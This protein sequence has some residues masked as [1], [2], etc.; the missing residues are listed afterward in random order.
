MILFWSL[1]ALLVLGAL[2][3]VLWPLLRVR[4]SGTGAAAGISQALHDRQRNELQ[5][6]YA[7]G[8]IDDVQLIAAGRE[9]ESGYTDS[10]NAHAT[11]ATQGRAASLAAP[12]ITLFLLPIVAVFLY[13]Y[14]GS[15]E[16]VTAEVVQIQI[17][18]QHSV[19]DM[20]VRLKERLQ[21]EPDDA[22]GWMLLGRSYM[23]MKY[24]EEAAQAFQNASQ[25]VT[26]DSQLL[27]DYAEALMLA[28]NNNFSEQADQLVNQALELQPDNA[29]AL[30]IAGISAASRGDQGSATQLWRKLLPLLPPGSEE[31]TT[32][33]N[34]IDE[35]AAGGSL[36]LIPSGSTEGASTVSQGS[37]I[38][39]AQISVS[40]QLSPELAAKVSPDDT[41]FIFARAAQGP[42][43]PLAIVRGTAADLPRQ[44]VLDDAMA[45]T[46]QMQLSL[47]EQVVVGARI[48]KSGNAI[49][50]EGDLQGISAVLKVSTA[51][52][53]IITI[54]QVVTQQGVK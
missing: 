11:E 30:W 15:S 32:L 22:Q 34:Y 52:P 45:M 5:E 21:R 29:K 36:E 14:L 39:G 35:A 43:M 8:L 13:L 16:R 49:A 23:M 50:Q 37:Q 19:D 41:L 24:H 25:R 6:E 31:A 4:Q 33:Q 46:P 44:V 20:V 2:A 17:T 7:N 12:A 40:V 10:N 47:F 28:S 54:D 18:G 27:A 53:V 42:K 26:G 3:A 38:S 9:L 1:S 48:S 51:E